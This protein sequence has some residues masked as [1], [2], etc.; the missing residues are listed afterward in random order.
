MELSYNI[1][2]P[3]DVAQSITDQHLST[4][5]EGFNK[6]TPEETEND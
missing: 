4:I 2:L 1:A 6:Y 5:I 3:F